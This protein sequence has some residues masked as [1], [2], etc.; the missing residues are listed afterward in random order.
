MRPAA[1]ALIGI[2]LCATSGCSLW[3]RSEPA[4]A[5]EKIVLHGLIA[6]DEATIRPGSEPLLAEAAA[7]LNEY[8]NLGVIVEGHSDSLGDPEYN[9]KLS[10][11]RA[12]AARDYLAR[13][14]VDPRRIVVIGKGASE[15][16]ASNATREGRARNRRV[17]L[18]VYQP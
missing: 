11:R 5:K 8:G 12:E 6:F 7:R 10:V 16:I 2:A 3:P 13:L 1:I 15:P 18:V 17:V 14:G 4:P 9:Q